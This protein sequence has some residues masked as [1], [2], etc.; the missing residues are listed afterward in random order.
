MMM[1]QISRRRALLCGVIGIMLFSGIFYYRHH[2]THARWAALHHR[3]NLVG[4]LLRQYDGLTG[5]DEQA[6]DDLLGPVSAEDW[7]GER[8][9]CYWIGSGRGLERFPEY[10]VLYLHEDGIVSRVDFEWA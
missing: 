7:R 4:S 6:L 8:R 3:G 2:F 9:R 10:M 1:K 5:M